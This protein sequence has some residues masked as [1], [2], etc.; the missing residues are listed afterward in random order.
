VDYKIYELYPDWYAIDY[1]EG[2]L[3]PLGRYIENYTFRLDINDCP[4]E[5]SVQVHLR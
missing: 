3:R 5:V 2:F 4:E 1:G